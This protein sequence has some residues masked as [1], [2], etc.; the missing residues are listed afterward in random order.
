MKR[1]FD[2]AK[3]ILVKQRDKIQEDTQVE[4]EIKELIIKKKEYH[5]EQLKIQ[6]KKLIRLTEHPRLVQLL[7]QKFHGGGELMERS[8]SLNQYEYSQSTNTL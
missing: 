3:D 1:E 6:L 2:S 4:L 5:V 8:K 7:R